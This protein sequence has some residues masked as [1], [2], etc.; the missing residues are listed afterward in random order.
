[1]QVKKLIYIILVV[2]FSEFICASNIIKNTWVPIVMD[3]GLAFFV[4][5]KQ[6]HNFGNV[7]VYEDAE[8]GN[9]NGWH[10]HDGKGKITNIYDK[11]KK[12]RVISLKGNGVST[13][14]RMGNYQNQTGAWGNT[15]HKT[16]QWSM[17]CSEKFTLYVIVRTKNGGVLY[18][19][20][21]TVNETK[22]AAS[23]NILH[24]LGESVKD[25]K[26]HTFTRDLN[27]DLKEFEPDNEI[28]SV[29][30]ILIR[31][32]GSIDDIKLSK[33]KRNKIKIVL[34]DL[35]AF[36][37]AEGA[38]AGASGGRDGKVIYVTNRKADGNGS[39]KEA[40][41]TAEKRTI[42]FAI[43]GRFN[44]DAG[45]RLGTKGND[46]NITA[47]Y[48]LG[49]FT[50]AGQTAND[51]GGVHIS[52]HRDQIAT[53]KNAFHFDIYNQ[54]NMI[55]RYF[56]SRS[57]W[58]WFLKLGR[59]GQEPSIRFVF[60]SD[61]IIDHF[62]SGWSSYG[63]TI[64][65][66]STRK[67]EKKLEH[68]TVQRS[69]IHEG[70]M[71]PDKST[72]QLP[73][74]KYQY[75]HNIGMLL[76]KDPLT[77]N[78]KATMTKEVWNNMGE[79]TIHKNAFI[80]VSHRFP[81]TSGGENGK[82]RI[83]NN[84]IYGFNG[85]GSGQRL[86]R[87]AGE[88]QND[89]INNVY[90]LNKY[91]PNF[92][93]SNLYGYLKEETPYFP[94]TKVQSKA[95]F[96][97]ENNLFLNKNGTIHP[98]TYEIINNSYLMLY[99]FTNGNKHNNAKNLTDK[100]SILSSIAIE[101]NIYPVSIIPSNKVKENILNNVGG[102]VK[103]Y[104]NGSSYIDDPIDKVYIGWAKENKGPTKLTAKLGDGGLGDSRRFEK[105]EDH[106]MYNADINEE[107]NASI[108]DH[109]LD[110]MPDLWEKKHKLNPLV[111]NNNDIHTNWEIGNYEIIN[112]AGYTDL[113]IY[114]ADIAG[115]FHMLAKKR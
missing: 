35:K 37:T 111:A 82:F 69:L 19:Y 6:N 11:D 74:G 16:I 78:K 3:E 31:G 89:F 86:A 101:E 53:L 56:D 15:N 71:N 110:G 97:V 36:P 95:R 51:K 96:Y 91:S 24:G 100:D 23:G 13:A 73:R 32:S 90:Q 83:I 99:D 7:I 63:L 27:A 34:K 115:D 108:F 80:G 39:L 109:D 107:V 28:V 54:K 105:L 44:I 113:E 77:W 106:S 29:E 5:S 21:R 59:N 48:K 30:G 65:N 38:G 45:I 104:T 62:T 20:Y 103:F 8:N 42:V 70:I 114:L 55:L 26:W 66:N 49:D 4:P 40:L 22:Q 88:A 94:K 76:G 60:V 58:K 18:M 68:I 92:T 61:L 17:K 25:G 14:Y 67:K 10:I 50:F 9:T 85:D 93:K 43:G 33:S 81:N 64:L 102:N 46:N 75:N 2:G 84:Y 52:N 41:L 79:F 112:T 57:N 87:I 47:D 98:I 12:S 72:I 1:M